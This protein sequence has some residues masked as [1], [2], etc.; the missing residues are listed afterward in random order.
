MRLIYF[1]VLYAKVNWILKTLVD[2]MGASLMLKLYVAK[3]VNLKYYFM[4]KKNYVYVCKFKIKL[5]DKFLKLDL[6]I[7]DNK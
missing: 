6:H 2:C 3:D 1:I 5:N 7:I 4:L